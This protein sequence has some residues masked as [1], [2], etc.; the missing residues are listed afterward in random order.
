MASKNSYNILL[1][2]GFGNRIFDV[3]VGL[4]IKEKKNV[5]INA[6]FK[7]SA[8]DSDDIFTIFPKYSSMLDTI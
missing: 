5:K 3:I 4:Y 6:I 8:H 7:K 2:G 1:R